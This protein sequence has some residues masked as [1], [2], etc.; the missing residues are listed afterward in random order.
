MYATHASSSL[1]LSVAEDRTMNDETIN[2]TPAMENEPLASDEN[3]ALSVEDDVADPSAS[4]SLDEDAINAMVDECHKEAEAANQKIAALEEELVVLCRDAI[5]TTTIKTLSHC[6]GQLDG[7]RK[8]ID[9]LRYDTL[10]LPIA[11]RVCPDAARPDLQADMKKFCRWYLTPYRTR[12]N[13]YY[14]GRAVDDYSNPSWL[15]RAQKQAV[16]DAYRSA[17]PIRKRVSQL[18]KRCQDTYAMLEKF[19]S[20]AR[21]VEKARRP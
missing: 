3:P 1:L 6:E 17:D 11:R 20:L 14:E 18:D 16:V 5:Y 21:R 7:L 19:K 4:Q 9:D 8:R 13:Y 10:F 15:T 2:E 12:R